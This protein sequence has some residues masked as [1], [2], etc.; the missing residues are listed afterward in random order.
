VTRKNQKSAVD[1]F[2]ERCK[3]AG[4]KVTPQRLVIYRALVRDGSHPSPDKLYRT[5]KRAHPT[6][7]H[8]TVYT[9]LEALARHGIIS[10]LTPL[11]E[12]VRFDPVMEPHHH[13]VCVNCKKVTNLTDPSLD[14]LAIP[15]AVS[16]ANTVLGYTVNVNVLCPECRKTAATR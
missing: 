8:A 13:V 7:S 2:A 14:T 4:L 16:R 9:T 3:A 15:P 10:R 5:V 11:H 12:T 1:R 6:I